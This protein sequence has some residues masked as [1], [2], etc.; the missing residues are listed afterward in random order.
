MGISELN[1][2]LEYRSLKKDVIK[3]FYEPVLEHAIN[4]KRAVGYFRSSSLI[5][6][7]AGLQK[8]VKNG[9]HIQLVASPDLSEEDIEA[10]KY[11]YE[12]REKVFERALLRGWEEPQ[13]HFQ[14]VRLN[15]LSNF[16]AQGKL[17]IK[18]AFIHNKNQYAI[19]HEKLGL[20]TD[21]KN[22]VAFSGSMNETS[23]A[24]YGNYETIDVFCDWKSEESYVRVEMK[25]EAF[26]RIWNNQEDNI[27]VLDFPKAV[28]SKIAEYDRGEVSEDIDDKDFL[29][30]E[31][32]EENARQK[33]N[34]GIQIPK[35]L[36]IREYQKE[37]IAEWEKN[38]FCG[39]FDMA[40]GTGKTYTALLGIARLYW[41]NN[42]H[43]AV[44]IV[45]PYQHLVEQWVDDLI[46]FGL[47]PIIGYSARK[48]KKYLQSAVFDYN[49]HVIDSFCFVC[50]NATFRTSYVQ[51]QLKKISNDLLLVVDEAHN[52]GSSEL[53]K[54]LT[55]IYQYRLALSA[56]LERHNDD[57]GTE[58]LYKFFGKKCITYDLETAIKEHML[59]PYY[60]YP[61]VTYLSK[62]ELE[63][64]TKLSIEIAR[65]I[66]EKKGKR[67]ITERGK[68]LA[69]QRARLVA[70]AA[71]K[72]SCLVELMQEYKTDKQMLVYCGAT[73]LTDEEVPIEDESEIRQIDY[74]TLLLGKK[75]NMRV[76]QFTSKEDKVTRKERIEHFKEGDIQA[77]IAIKCLDEGV[78]IP[79]IETAFILA[80]TTNP[81]EYI[82]RRGRV[83]RLSKDKKSATIYDFITL[84]RHLDEVEQLSEDVYK[85]DI[86]L[87]KN[88]MERIKEF[89]RLSI[90]SFEA[91]K[92]I[93]DLIETYKLYDEDYKF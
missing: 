53:A 38:A 67:E 29:E 15:M 91:D 18:L 80:S 84:P 81:K 92:L 30:N 17:D 48:Y 46:K 33:E 19:F 89:K 71:E 60:Y 40:T 74:I 20:I 12:N 24:F 8:L 45:C 49:I 25:K 31:Y 23:N 51:N 59:T 77:L 61:V 58:L 27:E 56:T 72:C 66:C 76:A 37:A 82:Q 7:S 4:Y 6:I 11:G 55:D 21:G 62:S 2:E 79:G 52:F 90:N 83:L 88:E 35:E 28:L 34:A 32:I 57:S 1:L 44:V 78:N 3:D 63:T 68:K 36:E 75:L 50:T 87:I 13:N 16:I 85:T 54:T 9:G 73:V 5:D 41:K 70:G 39:I 22:T 65:C 69:I 93:A 14:E 86:S 47:Q 26:D 10:I 43:L 64:Y 42:K